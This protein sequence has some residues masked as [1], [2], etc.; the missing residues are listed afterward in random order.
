MMVRFSL[1]ID[2]VIADFTTHFFVYNGLSKA[3]ARE[4][5]KKPRDYWYSWLIPQTEGSQEASF[6]KVF[7]EVKANKDFWLTVP[8]LDSCIPKGVT[9][10]L[11]S[12]ECSDDVTREWLRRN[13]F[14]PFPVINSHVTGETKLALARGLGVDGHIDDKAE[15]FLQCLEGGLLKSYLVSRPWNVEVVTPLRIYRLEELEWRQ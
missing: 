9:H 11:T 3:Q 14:P 6:N 5:Y 15:T 8:V 1:D 13:D 12:R 2:D 4:A 7:Q 10:Y